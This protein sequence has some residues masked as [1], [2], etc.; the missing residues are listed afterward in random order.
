M[1]RLRRVI[2]EQLGIDAD[3]I[4]ADRALA[5]YGLDSLRSL[6]LVAAL[7]Q[8][9]GRRLPETFCLDHP[10]LNRLADALRMGSSA[11]FDGDTWHEDAALPGDVVAPAGAGVSA[12]PRN[13]LLTGA[14][15]LLGGYLLRTLVDETDVQVWCLVRSGPD[16]GLARIRAN[17]DRYGIWRE[18]LARRIEVVRGDLGE[19]CLGIAPA[20]YSSVAAMTDAVIHAGAEVDWVQP[21]SA[22]RRVNVLG[23]VE[24]LR[25]AAAARPKPVQFVSSLSVCYVPDGPSVIEEM[26]D[27]LPFVRA[28]PLGYAQTK[29]VAEALCRQAH[30]RGL[31]VRIIRPELIAGDSRTGASNV[32]D[33]IARLVRG[34]IDMQ[35][36]PDL[37][38]T[39]DALPVDEAARA[40]VR[41]PW[42]AAGTFECTH[43]TSPRPRTWQ[44]CVLWINL[45]GYRCRLLPFAA[46]RERLL[47]RAVS[48]RHPLSPLRPFFMPVDGRSSPAELYQSGRHSAPGRRRSER[49][50]NQPPAVRGMD[51]SMLADH[52]DGYVAHGVLAPSGAR[53]AA[54]AN[55]S[56]SWP[57]QERLQ[58]LLQRRFGSALVVRAIDPLPGHPGAGIISDLT[59]WRRGTETGVFPRLVTTEQH[60][61][62]TALPVVVKV[63]A[64]DEDALDVARVLARLCGDRLGREFERFEHG[65][66]LQG[67]GDRE[68]A[69]YARASDQLRRVMPLC[70]GTWMEDESGG[71][72]CLLERIPDDAKLDATGPDRWSGADLQAALEGLA[73][74]HAAGLEL[75]HDPP[76]LMAARPLRAPADVRAMAPLWEALA[77]HGAPCVEASAGRAL[78]LRHRQLVQTLDEWT[79]ALDASPFTLIHHDFNPRNAALRRDGEGNRLC[80]Y[81]W[82]L[83]TIG[84]P[85][86]DLAEFLVFTLSPEV[87]AERLFA[88]VDGYRDLLDRSTGRTW[89]PGD[90]REGFAAA[91]SLLLIDRL[92]FYAMIHR[93]RQQPFLPGV[94][95]TWGR[96]DALVQAS[97][98]RLACLS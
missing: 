5:S 63:K 34:C 81:D 83:A 49:S 9:T 95:R 11:T 15:G 43:L 71:A 97:R 65:I 76:L 16:E 39:L 41:A 88:L 10:T 36:A 1:N 40:M 33:L 98:V 85:Q 93:V 54:P 80:A 17:L 35:A 21:Y 52:I 50:S 42:P 24:V 3:A 14:T 26:D 64:R 38:W 96:L 53:R 59:A 44:E 48:P 29:C 74:I 70:Y 77:E 22:L 25:L 51:A 60:G 69:V 2:A 27:C 67:A 61:V 66:G 87:S 8:A 18:G 32:D 56:P 68:A 46:W 72:G 82:E 7:E 30:A 23:T 90:W 6:E 92:S 91:L 73:A 37:H 62:V 47:A 20:E 12:A 19:P 55:R 79:P 94:L 58:A 78:A 13:V 89:H 84:L 45:L 86:R 4:D 57:H 75:R 31:P 28:L